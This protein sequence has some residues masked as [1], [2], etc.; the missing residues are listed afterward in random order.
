MWEIDLTVK[1]YGRIILKLKKVRVE[2]AA[3]IETVQ[4]RGSTGNYCALCEK[5]RER[6]RE[7]ERGNSTSDE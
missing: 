5:Y 7:R 6:E 4:Q 3:W 1:I 2:G